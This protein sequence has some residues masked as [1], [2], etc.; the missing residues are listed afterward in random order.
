MKKLIITL[1]FFFVVSLLIPYST[2]EAALKE[3]IKSNKSLAKTAA[4]DERTVRTLVNVGQIA[5]WI[6]SDGTSGTFPFGNLSGTFYPRGS[7]RPTAFIYQDGLV[8]GGLV[9]DGIEPEIRINGQTHET[10]TAPGAILSKGVAEDQEDRERVDR[11]WRIRRDFATVADD[12]LRQDAAEFFNV[13]GAS[14]TSAHIQQLRDLYHEDWID[15]PAY[16]GAPFYDADGDGQYNPQFNADGTPILYPDGDEPG[17]A[18]GDQVVWFITNDLDPGKASNFYASPAIGMEMQATFWAYRRTDALGFIIFKEFRLIYKGR[19]ESPA[20]AR[21]DSMFV[22]AW[23]DPDVGESGD[24]FVGCDTTLSLGYCYNATSQDDHYSEAGYPPPAGGYDF[25]AGP[26]VASPGDQAIWHLKLIDDYKNLPMTSFAFFA[27]G[28]EDDDPELYS[29]DGSLHW[30]NLLRGYRPRPISPEEPWVN[31]LTNERTMFRVPGDP[32]TGTGWID[33]NNGDRRMLQVSGPFQ[34]FLGDTTETVI[35]LIGAMGSDRLSSVSVLKFYDRFAQEAFDVAFELPKAPPAPSLS[36]AEQNGQIFLNWGFD[37]DAVD[38]VENFEDKG[39][40]FEGYNVYQLPNAGASAENGLKLA[41]Y[42][43]A[44]EVTTITQQTFDPPS[45]QVLNLPVQIG[46]NSG[47]SRT[48]TISLDQ[49]REKPLANGR[50][51][52]F[53]V[54]AYSYNPDPDATTRMLESTLS[55]VTVTPQTAKPGVRLAS[56]AGD[57]LEVNHTGPSDG[58]VTP[59][60]LD[61]NAAT[62]DEYKVTFSVDDHGGYVWNL[63]NMTAGDT[64]LKNQEN[65]TGDDNYLIIDGIQVKVAGPPPGMIDY[66]VPSGTR[67]FTWAGGAGGWEMGGFGGAIGWDQP[68]TYWGSGYAYPVTELKHTLFKLASVDA[69]GNFDPNDENVSYGYR[70]LRQASGDPA[71]PEFAPYIVNT[72]EASGASYVFQGFEKSIPLS[73]WDVM[74]PDNPRRLVVAHF[75]NNVEEG[76]VDG[77]YWPPYYEDADNT[78]SRE[79]LFVYDE[80]YSETPNPDYEIGIDAQPASPIMWWLFVARRYDGPW[81]EAGTGTDQF[82][83]IA[84]LPNSESDEFTFTSP[85]PTYAK[86]TAKADVKNINVFPNPYYGFNIVEKDRYNRYVTFSHLPEKATIRIFTLAGV[87]VKTIEKDNQ[88]QFTTWDLENEDGLPA[89]SGVYITYIDM[90]DLD[91]TKILKVAIVREQQFLST[92]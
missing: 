82:T 38:A 27:S 73:A 34:M 33:Q 86:N 42:D 56:V 19:E 59:I 1:L 5:A 28:Q 52:F 87:L 78:V 48:M 88:S 37:P 9:K 10:G 76:L 61:P 25:F 77:K 55:I 15:W 13:T 83:I 8:W 23:A 51:Y 92:Y 65:Q 24:D 57:T 30:W 50:T 26:R 41:T 12:A 20:N 72:E 29:Y 75:E 47:L 36:M 40:V 80:D 17:Y 45:G 85:A 64:L 31:P 58:I 3:G 16:K 68:A 43:L 18:D 32:V 90:P 49:L 46:N 22:C 69:D 71:K 74:D 84:A 54:S 66:D 2:G 70:Y 6:E 14:V 81:S 79:W 21:I 63:I 60:V 89:A 7:S 39:F 53:G 67:Q 62:G 91:E 44:N 35:A 11:V 4:N